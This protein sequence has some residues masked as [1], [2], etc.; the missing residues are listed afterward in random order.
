M[1]GKTRA[2]VTPIA[3]TTRDAIDSIL[4]FHGEEIVL[5]DTAGLRKK[6]K[7]KES[8][9]FYSTMRT[10][11][12]LDRCNIAIVVLDV[13]LGLEKQDLQI[14][15]MALEAK[16]GVLVAVNKW[17]VV[18]KDTMTASHYERA[19]REKLR[20]HDYVPIMFISALKKQR[21]MKLMDVAQ[22]IQQERGNAFRQQN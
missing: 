11:K 10:V 19:L 1:L 9:E 22:Q 7:I 2:I 6:S 16:R 8:V 21:V 13:V 18:E 20:E 12:A 3:G 14:V 15:E 17:D 4:K 5:I